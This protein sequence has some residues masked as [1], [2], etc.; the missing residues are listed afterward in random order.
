MAQVTDGVM[1]VRFYPSTPLWSSGPVGILG[2]MANRGGR[3]MHVPSDGRC[4]AKKFMSQW[5][6][7]AELLAALG[8]LVM[9]TGCGNK[10]TEAK[11][12]GG[13]A[14]PPQPQNIS[15]EPVLA[16]F[17]QGDRAGAVEKFLLVDWT[18]RPLFAA[19]SALNLSEQEFKQRVLA[20]WLTLR[21]GPDATGKEEKGPAERLIKEIETLRELIGAVADEAKQAAARGDTTMARRYYAAIRECGQ[22]LQ[23]P[24]FTLLVQLVGRK[25]VKLADEELSKLN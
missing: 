5:F 16:A 7:L 2:W 22:T 9:A 14:A 1:T 8:V 18:R 17:L 25:F 20:L 6:R 4:T 11:D 3:G 21:P 13:S 24:E 10:G 15:A 19:D 23:S 12:A